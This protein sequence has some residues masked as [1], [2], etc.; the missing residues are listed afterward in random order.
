M[1]KNKKYMYILIGV[2]VLLVIGGV[3]AYYVWESSINALIFGE[4][5]SPEIAFVG[6]S[7]I[8]GTDIRPVSDKSR[9]LTKDIEVNLENLCN[10][11]IAT[12]TLNLELTEFPEGLADSSFV[13]ELYKVTTTE[14]QGV[15]TET[16]TYVNDGDFDDLE[17]GDVI[18]LA[19]Q[20]VVTGNI[21]KY[22]LYIYL[23]GT[24]DNPAST[25]NQTF[26]FNLYGTGRDA[27]YREYTMAQLSNTSATAAFWGSSINANQVR[28]ITFTKISEKPST[29]SGEEDISS[30]SNSGDVIMWWIENGQTS[31]ATP[32]TLYDVYVASTNGNVKTVA[33]AD[34]TKMFAY[35]KNCEYIDAENLDVSN[36]TNMLSMFQSSTN[37]ETIKFTSW[38]TSSV[39]NMAFMFGNCF[40]LE[41]IELTGFDTSNVETMQAM[42][43]GC[44]GLKEVDISH[45]NTSKVTT[46]RS[47]FNN[48]TGL[49]YVNLSNLNNP[50]LENMTSMFQTAGNESTI[51]NFKNF[52][53]S[54]VTSMKLMFNGYNGKVLDLSSFNTES[55]EDMSNMFTAARYLEDL[56]ISSF[57]TRNVTTMWSM[58]SQCYNIKTLDLP[59]FRSS[60]LSDMGWMFSSCGQLTKIDLSNFD[61]STTATYSS[62]FNSVPSNVE[63]IVKDCVEFNNFVNKFGNGFTNLHTVN[64]DNCAL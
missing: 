17:E 21:S 38:N 42:F 13:W 20:Q 3:V 4:V 47:M 49:R 54:N 46:M 52:N 30:I 39:E 9:G 62:V 34:A 10:N 28:S 44:T 19:D 53:T 58:F 59:N 57:N 22:R 40:G 18:I 1:F 27:I 11:D 12:M 43:F 32:I 8:N 35:L 31:D 50:L 24:Q 48:S 61:F 6:G 5:C 37:L 64:N 26:R 2:I 56:N 51:I 55:V 60:S 29:V 45:F 63:V 25:Q 16:L 7:T 23:D 14:V 15:S 41:N 36:V 33:N